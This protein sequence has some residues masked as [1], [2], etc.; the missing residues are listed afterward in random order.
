MGLLP[1]LNSSVQY[2]QAANNNYQDIRGFEI[3]ISKTRGDWI[4]GFL[5]YTYHVET[6]GYFG[7]TRYYEDPVE[8]RNY[9]T[10]NPQQER[11]LPRPFARAN[12]EILSPEKF[13]PQIN[14]YYPFEQISLN[15][16]AE[17]K[18][19]SYETYNPNSITWDS[20]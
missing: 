1:K 19:G 17:W 15:I 16:L 5:N 7:Y 2:N 9:L 18:T 3:T 6:S 11:P 14:D 8:Q 10:L 13:G 4:S 12:I 20:K